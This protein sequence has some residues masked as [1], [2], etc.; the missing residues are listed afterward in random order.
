MLPSATPFDQIIPTYPLTEAGP[1]P[2]ACDP[3]GVYP[4]TSFTQTAQ[5]SVP[6][7][8]RCVRLENEHLVAV[9]CPDTGGRLISLKTKNPDGSQTET[10]FDSGVVRP[11][12]ILPRGAFIGGGTE[13][14]FPISHTPSLLEKVHCEHGMEKGRA[15]VRFGERELR[16]GMQWTGE[17]SLGENDRFLTQRAAFHNPGEQAYPWMSWSNTG[18]PCAPDTQFDF[19]S[20]PVLRHDNHL[21][22]IDWETQ[23]PKHQSD[24][25]NMSGYFW[26]NPDVNAFGVYTPSLGSGLYHIADR[27]QMPGIKLWSD[28]VGKHEPWVNQYTIDGRQCLELQAGPLIDQSVKSM[29]HP[30]ETHRQTEF[31][32]PTTQRLSIRDL[33]L[34]PAPDEPLPLY[35]WARPETVTPFIQ[36]ETAHKE[37]N[38]AQIPSAP[39]LSSNLWAPSGMESLGE[40]IRWAIG[41]SES[42]TET[43]RWQFQLGAWLA[44]RDEID[45]AL[46]ALTVS[47]DPRAAALAG[48]LFLEFKNDPAASVAQF[49]RIDHPSILA[50]PQVAVAYDRSLQHLNTREALTTRRQLLDHLADLKDDDLIEARARLLADEGHHQEALDLLT[51]HDWQLVHQK[52]SRTRLATQLCQV[53]GL[54]TDFPP[55]FLGEDNLAEFG[56]YQ[57]Y[58]AKPQ[59][60]KAPAALEKKN[61]VT[62]D[63]C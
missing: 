51:G 54:S 55:N 29:L 17:F 37:Q 47:S 48:R 22:E 7:S 44:A 36:L 32:I 12:R 56:A 62:I 27:A 28:G 41:Q 18:V 31:W 11:V 1:I 20:G 16:F 42:A 2:T 25:T 34:P 23:G 43:S 63:E 35:D 10:L 14:S 4:Y 50:H 9:V 19:P 58:Q 60:D 33:E 52:Y 21:G 13:L 6:K 45:D 57:E 59:P 30:G 49:A 38:P 39:D 8:Y 5:Q 61:R 26:K 53:L 3:E 15:F 40:S 46:E 24:I